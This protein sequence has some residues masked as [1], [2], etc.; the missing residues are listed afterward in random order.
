M[1]NST[2]VRL[3]SIAERRWGL[4]TTAQAEDAGVSRK[5]LARMASAGAIERVAQGVYRMAG[6]PL[7]AAVRGDAEILVTFNTGDFP[8]TATSVHD[9]TVVHPDGFLLDRLDLYPGATVAAL[10]VQARSYK[11]P[12]MDVED[13]LGRLASAGV[14]SSPL[15][16]DATCNSA[17]A[18]E[19]EAE[20]G[21][22]RPC[23]ARRL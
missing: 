10:R 23:G 12:E 9:I 19:P 20:V 11:A 8:D 3:G 7:A 14:P 4:V 1:A 17:E 18:A 22:G 16:Q 5:Q 21:L 6:A 13:L 2:L 15:R